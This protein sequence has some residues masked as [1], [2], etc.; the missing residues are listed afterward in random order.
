[1]FFEKYAS[2][3]EHYESALKAVE[4]LYSGEYYDEETGETFETVESAQQVADLIKT[5][6]IPVCLKLAKCYMV[7]EQPDAKQCLKYCNRVIDK[8]VGVVATQLNNIDD[9]LSVV[10]RS[11]AFFRRAMALKALGMH[12]KAKDDL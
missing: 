6:E 9:I 1:M 11:K 5:L 2:A 3:L 10:N 12:K 4:E 8:N 7:I